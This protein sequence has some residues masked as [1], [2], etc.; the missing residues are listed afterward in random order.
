MAVLGAASPRLEELLSGRLTHIPTIR[1]IHPVLSLDAGATYLASLDDAA[2]GELDPFL[3]VVEGSLFDQKLAGEGTF[4]R[5]GEQDGRAITVEQW[6]KRLAPQAAVVLAIG[7]CAAWGGIPAAKGNVTGAM[8]LSGL[9]GDEFRSHVG[10]PIINVPG[11]APNGD[12]FIE[13]L[14]YVLLHLGGLVPLELDELSRPRWL[15]ANV[16]PLIKAR[17][18]GAERDPEEREVAACS[19]PERGWINRL[20]GC[21]A[22]G[23]TCN[24]CTRK[25]FPD[26]ALSLV[27]SG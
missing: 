8:G 20:G 24:G 27:R 1:L 14:S 6:V 15:Y 22:I 10:L 4:S 7:T 18:P 16:T 12:A 26:K 23:G 21:G 17:R 25:D 2:R 19:V 5:L 13:A 3:L 11:C 9:L